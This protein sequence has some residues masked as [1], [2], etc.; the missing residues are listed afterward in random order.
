M[1]FE[2]LFLAESSF[3]RFKF[4]PYLS[5]EPSKKTSAA[6]TLTEGNVCA[7]KIYS[8]LFKQQ[9]TNERLRKIQPSGR[10]KGAKNKLK[11]KENS[12]KALQ[13]AGELHLLDFEQANIAMI[14]CLTETK[15]VDEHFIEMKNSMVNL[16]TSLEAF[17]HKQLVLYWRT[18]G[19]PAGVQGDI[20]KFLR[21]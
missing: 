8:L 4:Q 15:T 5:I 21:E 3:E 12:E 17:L 10:Q 2:F 7:N 16:F 6:F 11:L 18:K 1:V 9:P 14:E 20:W 13:S 19:S